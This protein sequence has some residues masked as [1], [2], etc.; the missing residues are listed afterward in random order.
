LR[1]SIADMPAHTWMLAAAPDAQPMA[2]PQNTPSVLDGGVA[3]IEAIPSDITQ[4]PFI[5]HMSQ[6]MPAV[7]L[8]FGA[9]MLVAIVLIHAAGVRVV[10]N[11]VSRR[12][13]SLLLHPQLWRAD[14]LMGTTVF[15]LLFLHIGEIFIW[16]AALTYSG[17]LSDWRTAGFFAGNTYTTLGYGTFV[18]PP[19]WEMLAPIM[20]ISGLFTFGWSASV[21]VDLVS[22]CQKIKDAVNSAPRVR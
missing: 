6:V 22:R 16:A 11:Y 13:T 10:T 3:Q 14:V 8:V 12:S 19:K 2:P 7:D 21:L 4:I 20:A 17:L 18:L 5:E 1:E 15:L 9:T